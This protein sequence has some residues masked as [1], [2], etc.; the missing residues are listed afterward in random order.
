[1]NKPV[2]SRRREG[3][4]S[5]RLA[6]MIMTVRREI[7]EARR[8]TSARSPGDWPCRLRRCCPA[9][10]IETGAKMKGASPQQYG[11]GPRDEPAGRR[12]VVA[13]DQRLQQ[14]RS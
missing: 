11:E 14:K 12:L 6:R 1:M 9:L 8:E 13:A 2:K 7:A 3:L 4:L 5:E 10:Q